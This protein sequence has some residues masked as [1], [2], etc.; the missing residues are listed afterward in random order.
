MNLTP[1]A[2]LQDR[3]RIDG[4][5]GK[6]GMGA[7]YKGYDKTLSITVAIKENLNP[8][9]QAVRQFKREA[10]MLAS[11]RHPNLPRVTDHFVVG[12]LQYLVMDYIE[13][14]DLKAILEREGA[15]P[16]SKV[17]AWLHEIVGALAYLHQQKPPI[18]HRDIKPAN[19]KITPDGKPVLVDFGIAKVAESGHVTTT[20]ARSLTPGFAPPEQYGSSQTDARSDQYSLAA[21]I[22]TLLT[23]Q[24]P[25][26]SIERTLGQ[27]GLTPARDV[28]P[29]IS[30]WLDRALQKAMTLNSSDRFA[31]IQ[32]FLDAAEGRT[33]ESTVVIPPEPITI[34]AERVPPPTPAT[35]PAAP[36]PPS[37]QH[38]TF[39][40]AGGV[41]A[42]LVLVFIAGGLI[43]ARSLLAP[44]LT[45]IPSKTISAPLESSLSAAET[46]PIPTRTPA[47]TRSKPTTEMIPPATALPASPSPTGLGG[48]R[49]LAFTSN[50]GAD[51][52]Y[53]LYTLNIQSGAV[54]QITTDS[55]EKG[56]SAWSADGL[57]LYYEAR[58]N[59]GHWDLFYINLLTN[60]QKNITNSP[61]DDLHPAINRMNGKLAFTSTRNSEADPPQRTTWWMFP[62]GSGLESIS[63]KHNGPHFRQPSEWDPAWSPDGNFLFLIL[64][65]QG[66]IRIYR[67]NLYEQDPRIVVLFDEGKDYKDAEPAIS[68]DGTQIAYTMY[69]GAGN[70]ICVSGTD[71]DHPT[72]CNTPLT[73]LDYNSDPDWSPDGLWLAYTSRRDSNSEIYRMTVTGANR[74]NLTN[75][76]A[77]DKYPA[78]QPN[79]LR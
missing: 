29:K 69:T 13:G 34:L 50:R 76:P 75:D 67:W 9:P 22:Y 62:D 1:G 64:S 74:T 30:P 14:E 71:P 37:N 66:P 57:V 40:I 35:P 32:E 52:H 16:E 3:Y 48:G 51:K 4:T 6:G 54:K 46:K 65:P 43:T 21:T 58:G 56:R 26:D 68:P 63:A 27:A 5:I 72:G 28:N 17:A 38:L 23:G 11:L 2:I 59:A 12:D 41:I 20:G 73:A 39:W 24:I 15:L 42:C 18:V 33:P 19:I 31:T 25:A 44:S 79:P 60:E 45:T 61:A 7:V 47:P 53:Q 49:L 78:W 36:V 8:L 10:V 55:A 70:Q 77:E